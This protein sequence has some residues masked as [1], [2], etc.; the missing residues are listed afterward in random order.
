MAE[1][2]NNRLDQL[3]KGM[4][5][6]QSATDML[7]RHS[8][9]VDF[10]KFLTND[11]VMGFA[12]GVIVGNTFTDVVKSFV[13]LLTGIIN[14]F[15][16]LILS[17]EHILKWQVIPL[18]NFIQSLLSM[19]LIAGSVFFFVKLLNN[20]WARN[21]EEQFGYNAT[22]VETQ[23]LRKAQ[24]ETNDLLRELIEKSK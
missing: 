7:M 9:L 6:L 20:V 8:L 17:P 10:R 24:E 11:K 18:D 5:S 12:I 4:Q 21:P 2:D 23:K 13:A 22:F 19:L 15:V 16:V 14:F 3:E 1:K